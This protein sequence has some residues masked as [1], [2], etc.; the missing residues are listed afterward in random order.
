V[1][2]CPALPIDPAQLQETE[3]P[4][5]WGHDS[6]SVQTIA[7]TPNKH[8]LALARAKKG[9]NLRDAHL[10]WSRSGTL[11]ISERLRLTTARI[12]AVVLDQKVL[13]NTWWPV[14]ID[15][16]RTKAK[17]A[18][19]ILGL[20]LNSTLGLLSLIAARVDTEGAW[21]EL[22]KPILEELAVLD[23][24]HLSRKAEAQLCGV[25]D[26]VSTLQLQ[27]LPSIDIDGVHSKIDSTIASA[28][29]IDDDL[30]RLRKML[31]REPIVSM[32]L[33]N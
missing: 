9:R 33:P 12:V 7:Q 32:H 29:G 6:E 3:Y 5:F 28:F 13:S 18:D 23:P 8:L 4:A 27:P 2:A 26:E 24:H 11:L 20:W 15:T 10:L 31:A 14:A 25:Y 1:L 21:I 17:S 30:S 22:K 19:K 16:G